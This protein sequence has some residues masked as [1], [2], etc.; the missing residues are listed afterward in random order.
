MTPNPSQAIRNPFHGFGARQTGFA[1]LK[2]ATSARNRTNGTTSP[3]THRHRHR[4]APKDFAPS[5]AKPVSYHLFLQEARWMAVT[6]GLP[7]ETFPGERR[8]ALTPR[9]CETLKKA[10]FEIVVE[11]SA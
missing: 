3:V 10:G 4:H 8:V 11:S 7:R 1:K 9:A 2:R 5:S 6:V